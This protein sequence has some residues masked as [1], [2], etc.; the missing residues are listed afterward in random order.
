MTF[1]DEIGKIDSL[2]IDTAPII[3][4]IEAHS[5][6][7][8]LVREI[9]NFFQSGKVKAFSSVIT[10][11]E[12]LPKPLEAGNEKLA[13]EFSGFLKGGKNITL[14]EIS[15]DIAELAG[16]LRGRYTFLKAMDAIQIA[17]S[18]EAKA[19]VF[20]TNDSKLRRIEEQKIIILRDY[21]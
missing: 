13:L 11:V 16:R 20:I 10:L 7:G 9:V 8:P 4:Y 21:L 18:L 19:D 6:F 15:T 14:L 3:Y 5:H 2:F 1:I 17:A 12:V